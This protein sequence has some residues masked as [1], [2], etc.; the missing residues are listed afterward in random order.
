[1]RWQNVVHAY[2]AASLVDY[3]FLQQGFLHDG[4]LKL[5]KRFAGG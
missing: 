3:G 4:F 5:R 2:D 1:V